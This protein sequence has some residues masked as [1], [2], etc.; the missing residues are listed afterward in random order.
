MLSVL[1]PVYNWQIVPLVTELHKQCAVLNIDY[2]IICIDDCSTNF[3]QENKQV[4]ESLTITYIE[5]TENIGRSK[6]RNLLAEKAKFENLLFLDCDIAI[7]ESFMVNYL[8]FLNTNKVIC[9]GLQYQTEIPKADKLLR[10]KY[11]NKHEVKPLKVRNRKPYLSFKS[12]NFLIPKSVFEQVKFNEHFTS[13]GHEDT[14]FAS[15]LEQKKV[16]LLHINNP[17][18]HLG[19]DNASDFLNKT[20]QAIQNL[21]RHKIHYQNIKLLKFVRKLEKLKADK[22]YL[23]GYQKNKTN[24]LKNLLSDKPKLINFARFKLGYLLE[25]KN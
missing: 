3:K 20:R 21:L 22:I 17:I 18:I 25:L 15:T 11:G 2:E 9:G 16:E 8:S 13:Y 12:C 7:G 5:L 4:A 1:L 23:K 24:I 6:T 10:W 14:L 19:I